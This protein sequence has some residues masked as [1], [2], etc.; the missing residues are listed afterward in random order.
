MYN[1][2]QENIEFFY[3]K[4]YEKIM[5]NYKEEHIEFI[6][7]DKIEFDASKNILVCIMKTNSSKYNDDY[8]KYQLTNT[9]YLTPNHLDQIFSNSIVKSP[10]VNLGFVFNHSIS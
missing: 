3:F 6:N 1:S 5:K 9:E 7:N 10:L 2:E 4:D 8:I